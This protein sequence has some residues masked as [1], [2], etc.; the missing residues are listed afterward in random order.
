MESSRR[1]SDIEALVT[2]VPDRLKTKTRVTEAVTAAQNFIAHEKELKRTFDDSLNRLQQ[3]AAGGFRNNIEQAG[4]QRMQTERALTEIAPEFQ[5]T[6]KSALMAWDAKWQSV[7]NTALAGHLDRAEEIAGGLNG[8]NGFDAVHAALPKIQSIVAGM[9]PLQMEPPPLDQN[10]EARI[11]ELT[12]KTALWTGRVEQWEKAQASLINAQTLDEYLDRLD[13]LVQSPFATAAQRDGAAEIDRLKI[14]QPTLL[15]E[16]LLP[17]DRASWNSLTNVA[18]WRT[19]LTPEQPTVREKDAYFKLRDDKNMQNIFVYQLVTNARPNNPYHTH[20]VYVKDFIARDRGG[21]MAGLVYDPDEFHDTS[22][23]LPETYSDWDYAGIIKTNRAP[24]CETFERI[25]LGELI[26]PNTGNYQKPILQLL[27][28]LNRD[29]NSSPLFRAFVTL[30]LFDLA[31]LRPEEWG[32]RWCPGAARHLQALK[33]LGALDLK[34]GDWMVRVPIAKYEI[35]F[36]K[37]FERARNIPLEKQAALL[38]QLAQQTCQ[39]DLSYAGFIDVNGRPVLRQMSAPVPEYWGWGGGSD[40]AVL[41]LR[42]TAGAATLDKIAEPLPLTPLFVFN[43]DRRH[44]LNEAVRAI[45]YPASQLPDAL[46]PFF[47]GL[48]E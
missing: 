7:R 11:R 42:K 16:L 10:L 46:P 47:S 33:D 6:G 12:S 15:G 1:V 32:L 48:Y 40:S 38:Q 37:Y 5:A 8:T 45:S 30:K 20:F 17:N 9:A 41:L 19:T 28:Q 35:S 27:D 14:D 23:F 22:R 13:Q 36:Q 44:L 18:A 4:P 25:G 39:V 43:G 26:D 21:Q 2:Q 3:L 31:G 34:S 29:D 24:E